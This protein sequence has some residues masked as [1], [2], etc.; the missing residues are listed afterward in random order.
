[1][2]VLV[3]S[4]CIRVVIPVHSDYS[5]PVFSKGL[6]SATLWACERSVR[7]QGTHLISTVWAV[8]TR[9]L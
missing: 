3:H 6:F 7:T 5:A 1:M 2:N 9:M 8:Y 4:S